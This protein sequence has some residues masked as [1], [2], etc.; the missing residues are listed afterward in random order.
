LDSTTYLTLLQGEFPLLVMAITAVFGLIIGSFLNVLIYRLPIMLQ[1]DWE[2]QATL[3]LHPEADPPPATRFSSFNLFMPNSHC[4]QCGTELAPWENIP[5]LSYI[6]LRARCAHC[7]APIS[8][9]Y[10]LVE[11]AVATVSCIVVAHFGLAASTL[12]YLFVSWVLIAIALIDYDHQLI[13]DNLSLPFLWLGLLVNLDG[14]VVPLGDAVIGAAA[15]YLSLWSLASAY[16]IITAREGMGYGDFKLLAM[17]GA[18][19]GWQ[20]LPLI[21]LLSSLTGAI[22]GGVLIL[23]GRDRLN[24]IPFGPF[25]AVAGWIALLWRE[26]ITQLYL[27][28][29][30]F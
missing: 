5:V 2:Q 18:W 21:V 1:N 6:A 9:R 11:I 7:S 13:P 15:G 19:M 17:L 26:P 20:S 8:P 23:F 22:L 16:R 25:L 29:V 14:F 28:L 27:Q 10:P 12:N 30:G 3:I 4:P 24:P